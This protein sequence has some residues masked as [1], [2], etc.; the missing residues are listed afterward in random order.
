VASGD[1]T[2]ERLSA[3][4]AR[5]ILFLLFSNIPAP[6]SPKTQRPVIAMYN[7]TLIVEYTNK[8][9]HLPQCANAVYRLNG[10]LFFNQI[11]R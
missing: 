1:K 2:S 10:T 11:Q 7:L 5:L 9:R 3:N 4:A 8:K 6:F